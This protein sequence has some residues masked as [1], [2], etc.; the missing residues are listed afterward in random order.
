M[1]RRTKIVATLGPASDSEERLSAL[2]EAGADVFRL[3]FSHGSAEAKSELIRRIREI[4]RRR[5]RAVAILGDLQGPKIRTGLMKNGTLDLIA[6]QEV[7]ITTRELLG[8]GELI[9][10]TYRELPGDVRAGDSILLDDGL[11][12]L[13][14]LQVGGEEVRCR[15]IVGGVLK[16]R[17]GMNLPGAHVSAPAMT[18]KDREDL[19]FCM[20]EG[21]DYIAL[22]FVRRAEDIIELKDIL[23]HHKAEIR[24]IAKIEKPQAVENFD[25]ILEVT[26]GVMVARGDLGV[27]M[28]PE[29]VP[30]IQKKIIRKCNEVGKPVITATQMLESMIEHPRPTRAETSDVANA[31]LDGT[32]AIM[33]SAETASGKYPVEAVSLMVRV[34]RDVER[35]PILQ[36]RVFHRIPELRGYRSLPEAIGQAAVRVAE[37]TGATAILAFTQ[38]GSTAAM[39]AKYRPTIPIYAVTPSQAVRRR[40]S[41]YA[42][43]RSVRV[44]IR[45]D[46]E[47]QIRSVEEAVLAAGVVRK[48]E[49]VVITM[50]SPVSAP[51]TTNLLKVHRVGTGEFYEVH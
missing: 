7:T 19:E 10:T 1:F 30:L 48:G 51:G 18:A 22:S 4:S 40:L 29:L 39:V 12:E 17:K 25:A 31:I 21:V 34:A 16:D 23:L 46:T 35:E 45:G 47:A 3:N 13:S 9:P 15:V 20:R 37:N 50:G 26:D 42:G 41:L 27:E 5:Q 44:D 32:D 2:M 49:V 8:E 36:E 38:T 6:G 14:V 43:V 11:M 28:S 24:V 33:L